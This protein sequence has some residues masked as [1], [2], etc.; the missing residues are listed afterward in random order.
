[1]ISDPDREKAGRVMNAMLQMKKIDIAGLQR[2]Y[3][4]K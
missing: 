3:E 4:G 1:L 2:A